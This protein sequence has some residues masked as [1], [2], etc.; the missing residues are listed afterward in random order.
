MVAGPGAAVADL[1]GAAVP[2][3]PRW[4]RHEH[5]SRKALTVRYSSPQK[6]A[7]IAGVIRCA[8]CVLITDFGASMIAQTRCFANTN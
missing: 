8:L 7:A 3:L 4:P 1:S 2:H 5:H 6:P